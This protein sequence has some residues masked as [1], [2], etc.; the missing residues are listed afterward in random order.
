MGENIETTFTDNLAVVYIDFSDVPARGTREWEGS[1][2]RGKAF[3]KA[4]GGGE[5]LR[6]ARR[7]AIARSSHMSAIESSSRLL[8][9]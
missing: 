3:R 5:A 6:H 4:P 7:R 1:A 9:V 8:F 2:R